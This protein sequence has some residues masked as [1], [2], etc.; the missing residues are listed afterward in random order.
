MRRRSDGVVRGRGYER[1]LPGRF[2][3]IELVDG[4]H[5]RG[6][7]PRLTLRVGRGVG[8]GL[9]HAFLQASEFGCDGTAQAGANGGVAA[10][11]EGAERRPAASLDPLAERR[12]ADVAGRGDVLEEV[13]ALKIHPLD[14]R[15]FG[16]KDIAHG[17]LMR[18][19]AGR[20][21]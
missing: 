6:E 2:L 15:P 10:E 9:L 21:R 17:E 3:G 4:R 1:A 20:P 16:R 18:L 7:F 12:Q 8:I 5:Q 19:G 14:P 11:F 13:F